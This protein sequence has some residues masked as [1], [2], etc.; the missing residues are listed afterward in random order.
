MGPIWRRFYRGGNI[1]GLVASA[2]AARRQLGRR[3]FGALGG[4]GQVTVAVTS[5]GPVALA[6]V[7]PLAP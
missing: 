2:P 1:A 7:G 4:I 5:A 3:S 6:P